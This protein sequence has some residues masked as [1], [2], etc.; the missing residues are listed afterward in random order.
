MRV[1]SG[2]QGQ[3]SIAYDALLRSSCGRDHCAEALPPIA[4]DHVPA[5][6][7]ETK[8]RRRQA[9]RESSFIG[10]RAVK[11]DA[12][13]QARAECGLDV[14]VDC[15]PGGIV[16]VRGGLLPEAFLEAGLADALHVFHVSGD[17]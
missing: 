3:L 10:D 6:G 7:A 8:K 17:P 12:I 5:D 16:R 14:L 15:L 9:V 11:G 4:A 1:T 13:H 2:V